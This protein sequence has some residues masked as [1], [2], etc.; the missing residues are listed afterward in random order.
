MCATGTIIPEPRHLATLNPSQDEQTRHSHYAQKSRR[1]SIARARNHLLFAALGIVPDA[2]W[3]LWIDSD[4]LMWPSDSVER[5]LAPNKRIVVPMCLTGLS[6]H[7]YDRNSWRDTGW[8]PLSLSLAYFA[9]QPDRSTYI[10]NA[11]G[12]RRSEETP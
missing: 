11:A 5:L 12:R 10:C 2:A 9:S 8:S 1:S 3:C 6:Q 7:L 4:L